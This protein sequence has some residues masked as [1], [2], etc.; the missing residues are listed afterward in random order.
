MNV[1]YAL[2]GAAIACVVGL[3][4]YHEL[5]PLAAEPAPETVL[6]CPAV[7]DCF[8]KGFSTSTWPS[9]TLTVSRLRCSISAS[10]PRMAQTAEGVLTS[11]VAILCSILVQ[12]WPPAR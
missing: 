6:I 5:P 9:Y 8:P 3:A 7:K 4:V 2:S 11:R 1:A 10:V 12:S